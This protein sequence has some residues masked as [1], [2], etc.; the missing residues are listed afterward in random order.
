MKRHLLTLCLLLGCGRAVP[1]LPSLQQQP[2]PPAT[3]FARVQRPLS[4]VN[5]VEL[6]LRQAI[7]EDRFPSGKLPTVVELAEQLGV[8]RETVRLAEEALQREGLLVSRPGATHTGAAVAEPEGR[9]GSGAG[10]LSCTMASSSITWRRGRQ[11]PALGSAFR[12][13]H[14][15]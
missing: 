4:I 12:T 8:S 7:A 9:G 5:Q 14:P 10:V 11:H 6:A 15:G 13:S 3:K 2:Q 1:L